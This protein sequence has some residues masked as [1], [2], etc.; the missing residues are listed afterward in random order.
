MSAARE[1][2]SAPR[3]VLD[4]HVWLEL[5]HFTDPRVATLDAALREQRCVAICDAAVRDEWQRVLHYPVLHLPAER[6]AQLSR[7]FDARCPQ[8]TQ[9]R[10]ACEKQLPRCADPDDQMFLE[11]ATRA[12]ACAVLSRDRELLRLHARAM[13]VA[14]FAILLPEQFELALRHETMRVDPVA[15]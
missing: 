1:A 4:T 13:R 15:R 2:R 3:L 10:N 8:H 9:V 12:D 7:A 6:I 5:L 14:G 11:L